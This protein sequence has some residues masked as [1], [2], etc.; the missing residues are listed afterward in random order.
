MW[1]R[2]I[3]KA[4][5]YSLLVFFESILTLALDSKVKKKILLLTCYLALFTH[6][7]SMKFGNLQGK[8]RQCTFLHVTSGLPSI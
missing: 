8:T 2:F 5:H 4:C 1:R 7:C 6:G 3:I